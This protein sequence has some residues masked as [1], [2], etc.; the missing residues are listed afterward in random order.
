M[1]QYRLC[2]VRLKINDKACTSMLGVGSDMGG[3]GLSLHLYASHVQLFPIR[4][5]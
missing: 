2:R 3:T 4:S 5:H 1:D